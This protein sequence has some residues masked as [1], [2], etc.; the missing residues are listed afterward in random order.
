[1]RPRQSIIES[2]ST[3]VQFDVDRFSGWAS[4]PKLRRSMQSCLA[5]FP[6]PE[7]PENFWALYWYKV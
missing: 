3:F 5:R 4:D 7:T 1:M 6:Q 2:F